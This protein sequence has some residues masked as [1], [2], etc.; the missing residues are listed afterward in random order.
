MRDEIYQIVKYGTV[1]RRSHAERLVDSKR[2]SDRAIVQQLRER[3]CARCCQPMGDEGTERE[4]H[5][6]CEWGG[7]A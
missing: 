6:R 7:A 2:P 4:I 1:P 3:L 5:A